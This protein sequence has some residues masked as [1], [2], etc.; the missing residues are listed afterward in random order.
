MKRILENVAIGACAILGGG[1]MIILGLAITGASAKPEATKGSLVA[2]TPAAGIREDISTAYQPPLS[3]S[4]E[5]KLDTVTLSQSNSVTLDQVFDDESVNKVMRDL[6]TLSDNN[7]KN[8]D[9]YLV[10]NSPGGSV[11]AG[12]KLIAFAKALPQKV[13]TLTI[14]AASMG[15]QTVQGLDERLITVG[16]TLM[17]HPASFGVQ[18]QTPY[19]VISRLNWILQM[20][21]ELDQHDADRM[22]ITL[23]EYEDLVHDEYW[24]TDK[25]AVKDHAADRTVGVRCGKYDSPTKFIIVATM[26]GNVEVEIASCPIIPG[27]ISFKMPSNTS[28][29]ALNYVR[30]MLTD[31]EAFTRE[32]IVNNKFLEYQKQ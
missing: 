28:N 20:I 8:A 32:Y 31:R 14:F 10:I 4:K 25:K 15:F 9:L 19:Q 18:G 7:S 29:G 16:G 3:Q 23:Q 5:L 1:I 30:L 22:Q 21:E 6:Q 12:M 11:E 2:P 13:K 26:F 17:S 24:V 27:I